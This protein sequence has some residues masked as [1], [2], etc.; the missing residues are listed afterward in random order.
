[1]YKILKS[2]N[3][4]TLLSEKDEK[5]FVLKKIQPS[6]VEVIKSLMAISNPYVVRFIELITINNDL[7][8]VQEYI[9]GITLD[10]YLDKFGILNDETA[11]QIVYEICLGLR[12]IHRL[13]I[14]HRDI[15]P[16]NI[17]I[18]KF[19]NVKIIDFGI[20]RINKSDKAVDTQILG[21]HGYAAPE[22]YGFSQTNEKADIYSLGVL[23]NYMKTHTLPNQNKADG[24]LGEISEKCTRIDEQ[25]RF[26]NVDEIIE[27]IARGSLEN[28]KSKALPGFR[29]KKLWHILV[30]S[31]YY[32]ANIIMIICFCAFGE[33]LYDSVFFSAFDVFLLIVP[34]F[35]LTNYLGWADKLKLSKKYKSRNICI[36]STLLY[37]IIIF[38]TFIIIYQPQ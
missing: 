1:M 20:S 13:G 29:T 3:S 17:M 19:N 2:F 15:T 35:I 10:E 9:E 34:V 12:D 7:F 8:C 33:N 16:K 11:T 26:N 30:S 25:Q 4:D 37:E 32:V 36:I 14:V 21:T 23:I 24:L 6:D 27:V 18:D 22:Q 5:Y 31:F 38:F 28:K